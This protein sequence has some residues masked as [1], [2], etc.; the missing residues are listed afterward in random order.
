MLKQRSERRR[1]KL[2]TEM[3]GRRKVCELC[4]GRMPLM[5]LSNAAGMCPS[6]GVLIHVGCISRTLPTCLP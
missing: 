2:D 4:V 3:Q 6:L 5:V 1:S